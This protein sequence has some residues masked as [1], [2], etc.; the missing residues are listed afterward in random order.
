MTTILNLVLHYIQTLPPNIE[1]SWETFYEY[2]QPMEVMYINHHIV[3]EL[4]QQLD[5]RFKSYLIA[6]RLIG[7][8]IQKPHR[9]ILR[10]PQTIVQLKKSQYA[11][12]ENNS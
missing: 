3:E 1:P 12:A 6:Y 4:V 10:L 9:E 5:S 7:N 8:H 11:N 2:I